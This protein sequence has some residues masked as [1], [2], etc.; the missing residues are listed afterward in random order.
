MFAASKTA[1]PAGGGT[2]PQFNYVTMLLH[3]D[4]TNGAQNNTF[5]DSST[6]NFTI[7]RNGNVTQG[8]FS[9]YGT[10]WSNYFD[11]N[12]DYLSIP[13]S[14]TWVTTSSG[15]VTIEFWVCAAADG[16]Y[17]VMD[18]GTG[19]QAVIAIGFTAST[20]YV[21]WYN[22]GVFLAQI[23]NL[24]IPAGTW[25]HFAF[26]LSSGVPKVY[27][28]G[29]QQSGTYNNG[30]FGTNAVLEIGRYGGGTSY[31]F[32]GYISNFRIVSGQ[33]LYTSSFTPSATPLT[34][35]SGTSLLT[36][37]SN[38]FIDNSSNN[39]TITRNGDVSVQRFSPFAPSAAYSTATIGGSGYFD[40]SGD[41]LDVNATTAFDFGTNDFT[42]EFWAAQSVLSGYP[43]IASITKTNPGVNNGYFNIELGSTRG[44]FLHGDGG[45]CSSSSAVMAGDTSW[46]H[47][48]ITRASGTWRLFKDGV[49]LTLTY[50]TIGSF[51]F[52]GTDG[53]V[54]GTQVGSGS[55]PTYYPY[56]GY[57][58]DFR[59]VKG[60]ALYTSNFTPPT[61][62]LTAVTNT[63]LLLNFT[64]AGIYDNAM[65][66][67]LETVGNAQ[68]STS[69]KKYGTG[70][71]Y[72]DGSG[73]YLKTSANSDLTF[74][75]GNF[76]VEC[77]AYL[78]PTTFQTIICLGDYSSSGIWLGT[79]GASAI[80]VYANSGWVI[81]PG[82]NN[83]PVNQWFHVALVRSGST[84][85]IYV[86]GVSVASTTFTAT[87]AS[88]PVYIGSSFYSGNENS[89]LINNGYI[90][91][92][93]ITK[94]VA[95]YTAN[96]T[97][98]TAAFPNQ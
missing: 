1:T 86:D 20:G 16:Y 91:D 75:A 17:Y 32:N 64:N 5:I 79:N 25:N 4:G 41:Y 74:G 70:S 40:G 58:S 28:N 10:L 12:G 49:S 7:T 22:G 37:Q 44:F 53:I 13:S 48:A 87:H 61:A 39:F 84:L 68:I 56:T 55:S 30:A 59:I 83:R 97:P 51:N 63:Q 77:W 42:I 57:L 18:Q 47:W 8:S 33:A 98:P 72:F 76:T 85:T 21:Y 15:S 6:N 69:V 90:D 36:C 26:V 80:A 96:F 71:M 62:P 31:Y 67:D 78:N 46:H 73:A 45:E 94:G 27:L 52:T 2:D 3:G 38:R 81:N 34:A 23:T 24:N 89:Q 92:L 19:N 9:P 43:G 93:R 65:M 29:V 88:S 60:T 95:R 82:S 35:V 14:S 11:G 50:D 54:V 66:N